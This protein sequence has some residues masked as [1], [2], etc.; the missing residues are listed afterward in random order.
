M[1]VDYCVW[2][3]QQTSLLGNLFFIFTL[4]FPL[5]LSHYI[6]IVFS[7][8]SFL[9]IFPAITFQI[10]LR[11]LQPLYSLLR[12]ISFHRESVKLRRACKQRRLSDHLNNFPLLANCFRTQPVFLSLLLRFYSFF[13]SKN[14]RS[15]LHL[16]AHREDPPVTAGP[17]IKISSK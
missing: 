10:F 1:D 9:G 5:F 15:F 8:F 3:K 4:C 16:C 17:H 2:K 11:L 6:R 14:A 7:F 12:P 13:F